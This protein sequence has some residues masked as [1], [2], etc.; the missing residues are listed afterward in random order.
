MSGRLR[1][2]AQLFEATTGAS[3]WAD[4]YDGALADIFSFQDRITESVVGII[5]P[6]IRTAEIERAR[7]KPAANLDAYDLYLRA[8]PLVYAPGPE[9]HAEAVELLNK[10]IE[11]DPGFA[12]PRAY[13]ALV[14]ETRMSLRVPPLGN[15]DVEAGIASLAPRS[16]WEAMILSFLPSAAMC[17]FG[18]RTT[19]QPSKGCARR[20]GKT[21]TTPRS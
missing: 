5:E 17:C 20:S 13:A 15:R 10:A 19:C 14:Y 9:G 1:V 8:L 3:L 16:P 4:R 21:R 7:R 2:T 11:L 12:L 18:S 6:T